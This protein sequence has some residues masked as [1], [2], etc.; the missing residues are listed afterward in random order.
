MNDED[1]A[2]DN[3]VNRG[4]ARLLL[5]RPFFLRRAASSGRNGQRGNRG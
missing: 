1:C 3:R 2:I 5:A 4:V